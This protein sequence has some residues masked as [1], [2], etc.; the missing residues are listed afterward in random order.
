M[1]KNSMCLP[2]IKKKIVDTIKTFGTPGIIDFLKGNGFVYD[3]KNLVNY[4][5]ITRCLTVFFPILPSVFERIII[6]LSMWCEVLCRRRRKEK[7]VEDTCND[8]WV[9]L[10]FVLTFHSHLS[11]SPFVDYV[12]KY[13][14]RERTVRTKGKII[15]ESLQHRQE[16][17]YTYITHSKKI[18][19]RHIQGNSWCTKHKYFVKF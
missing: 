8:S 13:K 12:Q 2:I 19:I 7:K 10:P 6:F 17:R 1:N 5:A 16:R 15:H 3:K 11:S 9:I 18:D 4:S 14:T